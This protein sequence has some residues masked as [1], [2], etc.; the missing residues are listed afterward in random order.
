MKKRFT[1]LFLSLLILLLTVS[2]C[3]QDAGGGSAGAHDT[4]ISREL[5]YEDSMELLYAEKFA[6]DYYTGLFP[7]HHQWKRA[8]SGGAGG[9]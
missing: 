2:G 8:V 4:D 5:V 6:V 9:Q 1:G 7:G 3:G